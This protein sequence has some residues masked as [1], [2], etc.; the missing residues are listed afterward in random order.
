MESKQGDDGDNTYF[1]A[2]CLFLQRTLRRAVW[3][4]LRCCCWCV[5]YS[6]TRIALYRFDFKGT[7][8]A[9][10]KWDFT[11]GFIIQSDSTH[12]GWGRERSCNNNLMVPHE[13]SVCHCGAFSIRRELF[14]NGKG[15]RRKIMF[16]SLAN[17]YFC[18][19]G[20]LGA[21]CRSINQKL[22]PSILMDVGGWDFFLIL[23]AYTQHILE[24]L[25]WRHCETRCIRF[26]LSG[27]PGFSIC[28]IFRWLPQERER[29]GRKPAKLIDDEVR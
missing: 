23:A 13:S 4:E 8:A 7:A 3:S 15:A 5:F 19:L 10:K 20:E 18:S 2:A 16:P 17:C 12:A 21:V 9:A 29:A 6:H 11:V 28:H 24:Y 26:L 22:S 25:S 27:S 1:T 14:W